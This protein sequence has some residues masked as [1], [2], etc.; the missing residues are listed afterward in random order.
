MSKN[1]AVAHLFLKKIYPYLYSSDDRMNSNI[2]P[3]KSL[4]DEVASQLQAKILKG[5]Y[6]VNQ[7]LPV[8]AELMRNFGVG[9]STI[10]EAVKILVNSGF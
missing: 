10:R 5:G 4:A 9:R 8:E 2:I 1:K 7:K 6:K 3:R